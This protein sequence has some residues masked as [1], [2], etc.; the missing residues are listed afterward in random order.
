MSVKFLAAVAA[1]A[2]AAVPAAGQYYPNPPQQPYPPQQQYPQQSYPQQYPQQ[3]YP[4]QGYPQQSYPNQQYGTTESAVGA[5]VD[6]LIGNRYAVTDRQA[7]RRCAWAAV[8][9]AQSQYRPYPPYGGGGYPG[10]YPGYPQQYPGYGNA[11]RVTA[12]TDVQRRSNGVR[13][14]GLLDTGMVRAQPYDPRYGY[15]GGP[16]Y[17]PANL[18]FRCDVDYR[19]YVTNVRLDRPYRPY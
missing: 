5:I 12:I 4:Q 7:I 16:G 14:R 19:G 15:G 9:Q 3:G 10:Q 1:V 17:G 18:G 13:V 6:G 8:Q 2:I 11:A